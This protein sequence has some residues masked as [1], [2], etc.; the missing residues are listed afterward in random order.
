MMRSTVA[1][2][3][4]EDVVHL[5]EGVVGLD[6]RRIWRIGASYSGGPTG[7]GGLTPIDIGPDHWRS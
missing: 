3:V 4:P 7:A 6:N 1:A 5:V 2:N